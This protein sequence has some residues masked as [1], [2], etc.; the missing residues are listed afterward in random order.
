[1]GITERKEREKQAVRTR[2]LDAARE[3]FIRDGYEAVTMRRI[4]EAIEYSPTTIYLHFKDKDALIRELCRTDFA[5]FG[6]AFRQAGEERD[7]IERIRKSGH[8]YIRFGVEH[9][10]HYRLLFMTP[11]Q[12]SAT[13][14]EEFHQK[15]PEL[16]AYAFLK[17]AV[18]EALAAGRFRQEL[19]D[20]DLISQV[21]W[22]GV[23]GVVA[24]HI[25][26]GV[27]GFPGWRPLEEIAG[28]VIDNQL[29]G[30]T[31]KGR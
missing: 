27:S 7:P 13:E 19:T 29:L 25:T 31:G 24:L 15:E 20:S 11:S 12:M 3:L 21:L 6:A 18:E 26:M 17:Q 1:M 16:D 30:L 2:I 10:N 5:L 8:A 4:A 14:H 9:P 23:H 22:A 28:A